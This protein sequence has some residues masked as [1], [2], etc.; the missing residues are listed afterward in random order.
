MERGQRIYDKTHACLFCGVSTSKIARHCQSM[1]KN[2]METI[3]IAAIDTK[4]DEGKKSKQLELDM[5]RF[6]GDFAHN[7]KVL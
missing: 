7:I 2:E 3:N 5:L 1:H 6:K 4:T